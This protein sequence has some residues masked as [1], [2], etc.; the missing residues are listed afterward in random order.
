MDLDV[1]LPL[2]EEYIQCIKFPEGIP[3]VSECK[4]SRVEVP[5][6]LEFSSTKSMCKTDFITI[7]EKNSGIKYCVVQLFTHVII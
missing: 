1:S 7:V 3:K 5:C 2:C 4:H 6:T